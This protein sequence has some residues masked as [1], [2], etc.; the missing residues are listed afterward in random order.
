MA[1]QENEYGVTQAAVPDELT[2]VDYPEGTK[3]DPAE[4]QGEKKIGLVDEPSE[5][6]RPEAFA[7]LK[8]ERDQLIDRLARLQAEFDNARKRQEREKQE[9]R[10]Y[11]TGSVVEQ[12]LPVLDNFALALSSTGT[13][14][15]LR[16]GV[17]LIVKQMEETLRQ[18]QVVAVPSVGQQFDPRVHEALGSVERDDLPDHSIAEEIRKGYRIRERLLR[19]AMVRI[20]SNPNQTEA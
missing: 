6:P 15:Q 16:T 18:L 8:A 3:N 11:A 5:A 13:A 1:K 14:E 2:V 4:S 10:D 17:E 19:P 9:F 12:F 20:V 7:E